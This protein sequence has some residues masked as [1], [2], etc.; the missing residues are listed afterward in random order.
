MKSKIEYCIKNAFPINIF[1]YFQ[2]YSRVSGLFEFRKPIYFVRDP[3][4]AK[5]LAIK[6]FDNFVDHRV[7]IDETVDK[8]FGKSLINLKGQKWRGK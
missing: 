7:I 5:Q 4:I 2:K 6:D 3:K 1:K 8:M